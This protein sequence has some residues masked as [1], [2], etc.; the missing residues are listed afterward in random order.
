MGAG[1]RAANHG[2]AA[3]GHKREWTRVG[4]LAACVGT[5]GLV[6]APV[7]AGRSRCVSRIKQGARPDYSRGSACP[8]VQAK[9]G[10]AIVAGIPPADVSDVDG[11]R[12]NVNLDPDA[13]RVR[14][15]LWPVVVEYRGWGLRLAV[16][17]MIGAY[18]IGSIRT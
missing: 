3:A 6:L 12:P 16:A 2:H 5:S 7:V 11:G 18:V 1:K 15:L 14:D 13:K 10:V 8:V 4:D 9:D 17:R